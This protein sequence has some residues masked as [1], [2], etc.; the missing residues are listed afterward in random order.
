MEPT[1]YLE[2]TIVSYLT[3]RPSRD[4]VILGHQA[5][6][7]Q[8]WEEERGHYR[9]LISPFVIEEAKMGDVSAAGKRMA[10]LD[11]IDSLEPRSDI[12]ELAGVLLGALGLPE[13]ARADALHLAYT[14]YY[15][16]DYLLTWNC[17]HLANGETLRR[18]A[19]FTRGRNLW[20]PIIL[21][22]DEMITQ[23]ELEME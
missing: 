9:L 14:V 17:T 8:W 3:A 19:T 16:V 23:K 4:V 10:V 20:L 18:L 5:A 21:T 1:L 2:T 7:R 22:P 15:E 13:R 6:T 12:Q 11:T